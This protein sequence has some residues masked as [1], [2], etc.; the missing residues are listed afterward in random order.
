MK[1]SQSARQQKKQQQNWF[2]E[3]SY[4]MTTVTYKT[5]YIFLILNQNKF[6]TGLCN[7]IYFLPKRML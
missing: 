4:S 3:L 2:C 1:W 6:F 5:K 7:F